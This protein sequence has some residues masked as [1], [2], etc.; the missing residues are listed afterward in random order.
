MEFP[1][2]N[3]FSDLNSVFLS[4]LWFD[5]SFKDT[6]ET[7][8]FNNQS[9]HKTHSFEDDDDDEFL[10]EI[11]HQPCFSSEGDSTHSSS[12]QNINVTTPAASYG[13]GGGSAAATTPTTTT[14]SSFPLDI[15]SRGGTS[16][17]KPNGPGSSILSIFGSFSDN[18]P[19]VATSSPSTYILS[20]DNSTELRATSGEGYRRHESAVKSNQEK[21]ES[22][23]GGGGGGTMSAS[24]KRTL[25][26]H[27]S[28]SHQLKTNNQGTKRTRNSSETLDHIMAERKRRQ[29][30]TEKFIALSAT[31]PG[32]KKIDKASILSE[33]IIH[34]KQLQERVKEFEEQNKKMINGTV[35]S[36]LLSKKKK[37]KKKSL[38]IN[39]ALPEVEA[40]VL[41][42]E[43]LIRIHCE[44]Q[45]GIILN[46][47][48]QLHSLHFSIIAH[49]ALPFGNSILDITIIAK[50]DEEHNIPV[51]ELVKK[52][53]MTLLKKSVD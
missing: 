15:D 14:V 46:L 32:L 47:L 6:D 50:G 1:W 45:K 8:F 10:K 21:L 22:S 33:A 4:L 29:E 5:I 35:K 27:N 2:Q 42:R 26:N 16:Q 49:S 11:F 3:W 51:E 9:H 39:E 31:I 24:Q 48:A 12:I 13:G 44:H 52:L 36:S 7:G 20:F 41:H 38:F 53:R 34:V 40:R 30:L 43:V 18:K 23:I 28:D 19:A 17:L 25:E 37:K